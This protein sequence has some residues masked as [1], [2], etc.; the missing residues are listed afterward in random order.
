MA[1][2]TKKTVNSAAAG[3]TAAGPGCR[4]ARVAA[5]RPARDRHL[6]G[7][8]RAAPG[9]A[10]TSR[11]RRSTRPSPTTRSSRWSR[12]A[13]R[14]ARTSTSVAEL[15]EVGTLA[16][17]AQVVQAQDGT[18]RAIVQ[19]QQRLRL[20]G[21]ESTDPYISARVELLPDETSE[22]VEV[23]ALVRTVQAQIEQYV[24]SGAPVPPE[25]AVAARNITEPGLLADMVAYSPDM[26]HRAAPGA[27]RDARR[28]RA[29]QARLHVPGSPDRDPRAQ[30]PHPVRGQVGAGQDPARVHPARAAQGHPARAGRGRPAAGRGR[31]AARQGRGL[32]HARGRS[33]SGRSRK[34]TA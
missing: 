6:P 9:R 21:F 10:A 7:D 33:R 23:Q 15:Y 3:T 8:D 20:L 29:P 34:S 12:S 13:R 1:S 27:A 17:I 32:G 24:Q 26:T 18:V 5:R 14:S 28:R 4:T 22:D 11:S 19:G 2:K 25:A 31:R 30:G 16:K